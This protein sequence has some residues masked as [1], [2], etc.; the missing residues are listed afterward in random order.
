MYGFG[1][2]LEVVGQTGKS[3]LRGGCWAGGGVGVDI[4]CFITAGVNRMV[5]SPLSSSMGVMR[6]LLVLIG[7]PGCP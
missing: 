7:W 6:S 4:A 5:G 1:G 3:A 2:G